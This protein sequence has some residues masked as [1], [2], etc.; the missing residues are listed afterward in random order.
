M[1]N[2]E[3]REAVLRARLAELEGRLGRIE[4]HLEQKPNPDW[5]DNAIEIEMDEV[6][7]GLGQAGSTEVDLIHLALTRIK[8]GTYGVCVR[9]GNDI[10]SARLDVVPHTAQCRDCA[11]IVAKSG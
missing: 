7:E 1:K 5:E 9:C 10:S 8:N 11:A 4:K 6:L 3:A 2:I